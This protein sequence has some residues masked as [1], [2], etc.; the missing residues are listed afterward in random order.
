MKSILNLDVEHECRD[1]HIILKHTDQHDGQADSEKHRA[2]VKTIQL[3]AI[4]TPMND[5][6]EIRSPIPSSSILF[7]RL[8]VV[9]R[10]RT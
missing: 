2:S 3:I 5:S 6:V 1:L 10:T 4:T 8:A 7:A 9:A